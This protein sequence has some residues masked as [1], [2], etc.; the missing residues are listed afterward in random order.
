[1]RMSVDRYDYKNESEK[2]VIE[3]VIK[4]IDQW[5]T[6]V[7]EASTPTT[8]DIDELPV[9]HTLLLGP[10][11]SHKRKLLYQLVGHLYPILSMK[12]LDDDNA[13]V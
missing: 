5:L 6:T 10:L 3:N 11:D 2:T 9:T 4:Q 13:V 7:N 8:S 1:M 12:E